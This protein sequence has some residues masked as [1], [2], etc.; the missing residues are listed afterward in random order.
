VGELFLC[1]RVI[2]VNPA[3]ITIDNPGQEDCIITVP[4]LDPSQNCIRLNTLLQIKGHKNQHFHPVRCNFVHRLP[5]Y[6]ST[7]IY[8]CIMLLQLLYRWQQQSLKLWIQSHMKLNHLCKG[9]LHILPLTFSQ[10]FLVCI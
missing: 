5:V 4:L 10:T 7:I 3:I 9:V 1:L 8:C 2:T 6:T